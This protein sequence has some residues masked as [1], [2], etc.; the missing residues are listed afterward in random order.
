MKGRLTNPYKG[1][2]TYQEA[3]ASL[4]YGRKSEIALLSEQVLSR[5]STIISGV[6]GSGKSSLINA[7]LFPILRDNGIIPIKITPNEAFSKSLMDIWDIFCEKI[8]LTI[9]DYSLQVINLSKHTAQAGGEKILDKLTK[10]K[11]RD[12]FGFNISFALIIDQ[13]EE[14]F[15]K[16]LNLKEIDKFIISYQNLCVNT[17]RTNHKFV[18]SVRQDYLFE[19][20]RYS[21]RFPLLQQNRFHLAILNEEQAY[22]VITSPRDETG[23]SYFSADDATFI[24]KNILQT[25]DFILDGIPEQEVD[26]MLL[27]LYLY[28]A[29]ESNINQPEVIIPDP[30]DILNKFYSDYMDFEGSNSLESRLISDS[31]LYR[32][33]ITQKD[34]LRYINGDAKKLK[35]LVDVGIINI[36]VRSGTEF[37]ELHHDR[38][39]KCASHHIA[40]SEARK[41]NALKFSAQ[42]YL[43]IKNRVFHENSYWFLTRGYLE[44]YSYNK[45]KPLIIKRLIDPKLGSSEDFACFFVESNNAKS[46]SVV[47][48]LSSKPGECESTTY[49]GISQFELKYV[50]G[51]LYSIS[52]KGEN[53]Q[54]ISIYTGTS[55][56]KFFYDEQNRLALIEM[57]DIYGKK[58]IVKDGY[59]SI[60]YIYDTPTDTCPSKTFYLNLPENFLTK[61]TPRKCSS[62]N[63]MALKYATLHLEGNYGYESHYNSY[64][65]EDERIFIDSSGQECVLKEGFSRIKF[66][67]SALDDLLK[68]SYF[69]HEVPVKNDKGIHSIEIEYS[70]GTPGN[71]TKYYDTDGKP[72]HLPDGSYGNKMIVDYSEQTYKGTDKETFGMSVSF[73]YLDENGHPCENKEHTLVQ[74]N[75]LDLNY[76][77]RVSESSDANNRIVET[78]SIQTTENG[79]VEKC[80]EINVVDYKR[81]INFF[82]DYDDKCR[83]IVFRQVNGDFSQSEVTYEYKKDGNYKKTISYPN[84]PNTTND[85]QVI[86]SINYGLS[87][88]LAWEDD[89]YIILNCN[90][91]GGYT[92]GYICDE[93]GNLL[94]DPDYKAS[95]LR[96]ESSGETTTR[97]FMTEKEQPILKEIWKN[98]E[99][100]YVELFYKGEWKRRTYE[101]G[102]GYVLWD[103]NINGQQTRGYLCEADGTPISSTDLKYN[104]IE[105]VYEHDIKV[106]EIF[107]LSGNPILQINYPKSKDNALFSR[108]EYTYENGKLNLKAVKYYDP[109]NPIAYKFIDETI[110]SNETIL[111]ELNG[112]HAYECFYDKERCMSVE[113]YIDKNEC[114]TNGPDGWAQ[115]QYIYDN[116][117]SPYQRFIKQKVFR[118]SSDHQVNAIM[119]FGHKGSRAD[120]EFIQDYLISYKLRHVTNKGKISQIFN[121][122]TNR[123]CYWKRR[124][125]IKYLELSEFFYN[126]DIS[127]WNLK[128]EKINK[129]LTEYN[130]AQISFQAEDSYIITTSSGYVEILFIGKD[131]S[132]R[133][134]ILNYP[135]TQKTQAVIRITEAHPREGYNLKNNDVIIRFGSW[136][137]FK[138]RG[139]NKDIIEPFETEFNKWLKSDEKTMVD[140]T[141]ARKI[142]NEWT[143]FSGKIEHINN[144]P[145]LGRIQD[146]AFPIA[147]IDNI[148]KAFTSYIKLFGNLIVK[149]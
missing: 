19:V 21:V 114:I 38:L 35:Q 7:G 107:K 56:Y 74:K 18:V 9:K 46:Y 91:D 57:L 79:L 49:D 98:D 15:Q 2:K 143:F 60:L 118:D 89:K 136:D 123:F 138:L 47:V 23:K 142:A 63:E 8:D 16:K 5:K 68:L 1:L 62:F 80:S 13:F 126:L 75:W 146:S 76:N 25:S 31:G 128:V 52:F 54:P 43:S 30:D 82:I 109:V 148:Y 65:C 39:C 88:K 149:W 112:I 22:E 3:D 127:I 81:A 108:K 140:V 113:R 130:A 139:D 121:A 147:E 135:Q 105:Y 102:L 83:E 117:H 100:L 17:S 93:D 69:D 99:L 20:D 26:A 86:E 85:R 34:A 28:Q 101:Q 61:N 72:A 110:S 32:L 87:H 134:E 64:G 73:I 111:S 122:K 97:T 115:F 129:Q 40:V 116:D 24:L 92:D 131:N 50:K 103:I 53:S 124:R 33:S 44:H 51:L 14:I 11:Y 90:K 95:L 77:I 55:T 66:V 36:S 41:N 4:F 144:S 78:M 37:I 12:E 120:I 84:N 133:R 10:S 104:T 106:A 6:S 119:D 137:Y 125:F 145:A 59:S 71:I 141:I 67:K 27:S 94:E 29:V 48:K 58:H 96:L 45:L 42:A 132:I 70:I